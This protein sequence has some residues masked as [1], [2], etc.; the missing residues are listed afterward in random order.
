MK[1]ILTISKENKISD[2]PFLKE[3][4]QEIKECLVDVSATMEVINA[5]ETIEADGMKKTHSAAMMKRVSDLE[6]VLSMIGGI[7]MIK[8]TFYAVG[9]I[10]GVNSMVQAST[11]ASWENGWLNF[12]SYGNSGDNGNGTAKAA[13]AFEIFKSD[14]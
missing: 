10:D 12:E 11:F 13:Y 5:V 8:A 7:P 4:R 9:T 2:V 6:L 14:K 3:V 1:T